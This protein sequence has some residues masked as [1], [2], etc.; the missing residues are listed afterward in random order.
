VAGRPPK[1]AL[2]GRDRHNATQATSS[3]GNGDN[4]RDVDASVALT[5]YAMLSSNPQSSKVCRGG[6]SE[7]AA[8]TVDW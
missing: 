6:F 7:P 3:D 2:R 1:K 4:S 5:I 8:Y